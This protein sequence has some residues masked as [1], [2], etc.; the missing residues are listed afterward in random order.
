MTKKEFRAKNSN[1]LYRKSQRRKKRAIGLHG[2]ME[3]D[4]EAKRKKKKMELKRKKAKAVL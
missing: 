4:T 2:L 3:Q 1:S